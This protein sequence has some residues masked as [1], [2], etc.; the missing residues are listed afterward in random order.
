M[1]SLNTIDDETEGAANVL[2]VIDESDAEDLLNV[3]GNS[4]ATWGGTSN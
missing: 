2:I 4:P 3:E 1:S